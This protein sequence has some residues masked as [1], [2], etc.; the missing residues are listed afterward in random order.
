MSLLGS[1]ANILQ[2]T[3]TS[4]GGNTL[5]ISA[6]SAV[7]TLT[8]SYVVQLYSNTVSSTVGATL[9]A[10]SNTTANTLTF[11]N[12]LTVGNYYY[13]VVSASNSFGVSPGKVS[14]IVQR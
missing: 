14:A 8:N 3:P 11:P 12:A 2:S 10:T 5:A 4:V 13:T 9:L 1:L 7:S 6:G